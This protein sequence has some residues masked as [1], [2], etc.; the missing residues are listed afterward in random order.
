MQR[1]APTPRQMLW[2]VLGAFVLMLLFIGVGYATTSIPSPNS[3]ATRQATQI[4]YS[5]GK[6]LAHLGDTNRT[7]VKL[8]QVPPDVQHAVL[9]AE[10]RNFQSEPGISPTG[11]MRALFV[12]LKGG[13]VQGGSTITQQYVKN[14]YLTQ[15]RTF[16]RKLKEIFIWVKLGKSRSKDQI[17]EDYLNTIYFGRGA[18]GI[19]AAAH[20]Y[21]NK[22]VSN[23]NAAQGALLASII[24]NPTLYSPDTNKAGSQSRFQYVIGGMEKKG[25]LS[26]ASPSYP[27]VIAQKHARGKACV[28]PVGFI[29]QA[30]QHSLS[31][32]GFDE[33][34]LEAGGYRVV[35]TISKKAEDAARKAM[36]D[37][38]GAYQRG[39]VDKG[40][41]AAMV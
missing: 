14:A 12:D 27:K 10:D 36:A 2:G 15:E 24:S 38:A 30:V 21:F 32:H 31:Q 28:G 19:Q 22:D 4:L 26:G 16:S 5:N 11:I 34:R 35:S 7:N 29:C 18:Y 8:S 39:G 40:R 33:A 17:L 41:E 3:I 23:L 9:S 6:P 25:W 13:E 1:Y 20:A 37:Q